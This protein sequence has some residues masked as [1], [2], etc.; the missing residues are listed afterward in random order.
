MGREGC[1]SKIG[2]DIRLARH[3][4]DLV[5]AHDRLQA[6]TNG[7]SIT[8]F[9]YVPVDLRDRLGEPK[10][11]SYLNDVNSELLFRMEKSGEAF[12]SNAVIDGTFPMRL[13]I[14]N[15]RTSEEDIEALPGIAVRIGEQ[16]DRDLRPTAGL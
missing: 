12:L 1:L 11:E 15:F 13:C 5:K 9:R 7:L 8:T 2:E 3:L 14:V 16:T 10:V 6:F 4:F